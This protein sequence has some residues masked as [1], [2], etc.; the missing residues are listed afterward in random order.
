[1]E[2]NNPLYR[3]QGIHLMASIFT[4]EKGITKVLL[5]KRK[6]EPFKDCWGLVGG[7][8]YNNEDIEDGIRREILEK[9]GITDIE[10]SL[11][12]VFGKFN[13]SPVMRMVAI[14][15]FG[16]IDCKKVKILNETLKTSN[17]DWFAINNIPIDLAYDHNEIINDA[18][19]KLKEKIVESDLLKVLFP[20]GFT[21]PEIQKVYESILESNFDRR[22]FRKKLLSLDLIIDT[23][24]QRL[25]EGKKPAKLYKFKNKKGNKNVF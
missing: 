19:M 13:R 1:M 23:N 14:S 4:V 5:I 18:L 11:C 15:Y 16:V 7:A 9:T 25:F 12:N 3:N 6:N 21:M 22:N 17:A 24:K 2:I 10:L 20:D 8:L